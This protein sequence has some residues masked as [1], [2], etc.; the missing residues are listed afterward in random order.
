MGSALKTSLGAGFGAAKG[1]LSRMA[2]S[3]KSTAMQVA[4]LGGAFSLGAFASEALQ[5]EE[6]AGKI[7]Q[8]LRSMG[9]DGA[10]AA[11]VLAMMRG[12]SQR[13]GATSKELT[14]AYDS[15]L[16]ATGEPVFSRDA[17][18]SV[19]TFQDAFRISAEQSADLVSMLREKAGAT[20]DT[21]RDDFGPAL[22]DATNQGGVGIDELIASGGKLLAVMPAI[23]LK[24]GAGMTKLVGLLNAT[25]DAGGEVQERVMQIQGMLIRFY[26]PSA[27]KALKKDLHGLKFAESE[28][29][30]Q[31]FQKVLGAKGGVDALQ[32]VLGASPK[33]AKI[34]GA[35]MKPFT[36]AKEEAIKA[37]LTP[38][39]AQELGV[40]AVRKKFEEVTRVTSTAATLEAEAARRRDETN[41]KMQLAL[42]RMAA[43]FTKPE[44]LGAIESLAARMPALAD[45]FAKA[46]DIATA[47]PKLALAGI[48]GAQAAMSGL[49]GV[50][51]SLGKQ[52][53]TAAGARATAMLA[54]SQGSAIAA[55][56]AMGTAAGASLV[57]GAG[58]IGAAI[59]Y[60]IYKGIA[61][62]AM[63]REHAA[64]T[65]GTAE[66]SM[67]AT[68][69]L[70][71]KDVT[72]KEAALASVQKQK[73]V[74]AESESGW[75]SFFGGIAS[76]FTGAKSP[77]EQRAEARRELGQQE[78]ALKMSITR[79]KS[80][81]RVAKAAVTTAA[82]L[83]RVGRA[84]GSARGTAPPANPM[85]GSAPVGG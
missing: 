6:H 40:E 36:E 18:E 68:S 83:E 35:L 66:V 23:G 4:S 13:L 60:T 16:A 28:D 62:P 17:L 30:V 42:D 14:S 65:K 77:D 45:A 48:V 11:D 33:T 53:V 3:L 20:A 32:K 82:A 43:A 37:G 2:G 78:A 85:P 31:R 12:E 55:G 26:N 27:I 59:G 75:N 47:N 67:E 57:V 56:A 29:A 9:E 39:K 50:G 7:A 44:F 10:S 74:V 81:E 25:D 54:V 1:G 73:Q 80:E 8:R 41:R 15:L 79:L 46:I 51:G 19:A 5:A 24:G 84:A 58:A 22:F 52:A 64:T 63:Q 34:F 72:R 61:E 49:V 21:I 38:Q 69:A 76:K 70:M 71:S